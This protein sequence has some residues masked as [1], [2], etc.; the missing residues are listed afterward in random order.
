M[1]NVN[2]VQGQTELV[3][4]LR[5]LGWGNGGKKKATGLI[6]V[7]EDISTVISEASSL[8][9]TQIESPRYLTPSGGCPLFAGGNEG[10]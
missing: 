9:K 8:L 7:F 5:H 4:I 1:D 2:V 3:Q 6:Y 10:S